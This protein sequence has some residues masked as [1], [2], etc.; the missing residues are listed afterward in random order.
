MRNEYEL[1]NA[2][3]HEKIDEAKDVLDAPFLRI[4]KVVSSLVSVA[5][6]RAHCAQRLYK[7]FDLPRSSE[8][9]TKLV[10]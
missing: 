10:T 3:F 8:K 6:H 1:I 2:E 9:T 7:W 5:L 4:G